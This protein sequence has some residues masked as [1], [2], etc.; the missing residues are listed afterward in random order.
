MNITIINGDPDQHESGFS[1]SVSS[2]ADMLR[3]D[4]QVWYFELRNMEI[5]QCTGCWA[6][7]WKTPGVCVIKDD[8]SM[9]YQPVLSSDLVI[10]ASPLRVGFTSALL[11]TLQDRMI[12]LLHPYMEIRNGE[13][14]HRK[15][16]PKYPLLSLLIQ[17]ES[18]T[19]AEDIEIVH[20]IY[21]R[22]AINFHSELKNVWTTDLIKMEDIKYAIDN[23]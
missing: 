7:W 21:N 17:D 13:I 6:C 14:H 19:T 16:Y 8:V 20:D 11:K 22:F 5:R 9:V 12:P 18:D 4:H 23:F 3:T 15:R 2:L 10:F 1:G